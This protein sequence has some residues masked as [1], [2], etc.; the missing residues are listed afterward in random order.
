M[1]GNGKL[2]TMVKS[3]CTICQKCVW[4]K[5]TG[6][7]I[8]GNYEKSSN[9]GLNRIKSYLDLA[10]KSTCR[11]QPSITLCKHSGIELSRI[12]KSKYTQITF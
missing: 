11:C 9:H 7:V 6:D 10:V 3:N 8:C 2:T 12:C 1:E 5:V 4:N